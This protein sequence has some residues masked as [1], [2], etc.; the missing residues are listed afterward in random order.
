MGPARASR[1]K[2]R[3]ASVKKQKI[4]VMTVSTPRWSSR[5]GISFHCDTGA[6]MAATKIDAM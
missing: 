5:M 2:N 1:M 6:G 4:G 3:N